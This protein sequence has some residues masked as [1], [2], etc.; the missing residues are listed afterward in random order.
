MA[1]TSYNSMRWWWC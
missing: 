1:R